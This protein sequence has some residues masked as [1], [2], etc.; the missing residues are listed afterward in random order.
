MIPRMIL[1]K[2]IKC[3]SYKDRVSTDNSERVFY[4]YHLGRYYNT[5]TYHYGETVHPEVIELSLV[6]TLPYC[7][8]ILEVPVEH[9]VDGKNKIDEYVA[10]NDMRTSLPL[11]INNSEMEDV[12]CIQDSCDLDALIRTI[13]KVFMCHEGIKT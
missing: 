8:K 12:I 6:K 1:R 10:H 7:K 3:R 2:D 11:K 4:L 13:D 9:R 5:P